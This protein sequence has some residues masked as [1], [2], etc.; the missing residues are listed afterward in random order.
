MTEEKQ[1]KFTAKVRRGLVWIHTVAGRRTRQEKGGGNRRA[2]RRLHCQRTCR[3]GIALTWIS[4]N[5]DRRAPN[6]QP[7]FSSDELDESG[8]SSGTPP[9]L[10][11]CALH[12]PSRSRLHSATSP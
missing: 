3:R 8:T 1:Q 10:R 11:G 2:D 7:R 5:K 6:L 9:G 12:A 4:Q